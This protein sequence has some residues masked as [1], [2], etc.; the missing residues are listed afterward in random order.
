MQRP[1]RVSCNE[2]EGTPIEVAL[3]GS[4]IAVG[5]R[6]CEWAVLIIII[7]IKCIHIAR[8]RLGKHIPATIG[9]LFLGNGSVN[10]PP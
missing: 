5:R 1:L 4:R 3:D 10:T 2:F 6:I 8:Q 9:R 7:I